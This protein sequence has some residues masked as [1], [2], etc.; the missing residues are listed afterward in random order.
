METGRPSRQS[1]RRLAERAVAQPR[2]VPAVWGGLVLLAL[3][4][5]ISLVRS[6]AGPQLDH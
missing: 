4:R 1:L 3:S 2:R 6:A 5:D